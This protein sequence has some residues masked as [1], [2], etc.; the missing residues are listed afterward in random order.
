MDFTNNP[1]RGEA[2]CFSTFNYDGGGFRLQ[3]EEDF[4]IIIG[5]KA[6]V[7]QPSV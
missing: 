5:L 2:V 1:A 4:G 6:L 3:F 7:T